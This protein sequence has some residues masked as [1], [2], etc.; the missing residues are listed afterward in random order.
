VA[1]ARHIRSRSIIDIL[2]GKAVHRLRLSGCGWLWEIGRDV[3]G[4][5]GDAD[6]HIAIVLRLESR[7]VV[8]F[9][10]RGFGLGRT[11]SCGRRVPLLAGTHYRGT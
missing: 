3:I 6:S 9:R 4:G 10:F 5:G 2:L 7:T 11:A 1:A 8:G